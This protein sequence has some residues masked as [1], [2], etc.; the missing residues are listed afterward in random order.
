[1]TTERS[2]EFACLKIQEFKISIRTNLFIPCI[3]L[4]NI[5]MCEKKWEVLFLVQLG[6]DLNSRD[7]IVLVVLPNRWLFIFDTSLV[8]SDVQRNKLT[9]L[10][11]PKCFRKTK[12]SY[13]APGL[14]WKV[15]KTIKIMVVVNHSPVLRSCEWPYWA[16]KYCYFHS[17]HLLV[18]GD[19]S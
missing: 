18:V 11:R 9:T 16:N 10:S 5:C 4:A 14:N 6:K 1:M 17:I 15:K 8:L 12:A 19:S 2:M 3:Q 13:P 7:K